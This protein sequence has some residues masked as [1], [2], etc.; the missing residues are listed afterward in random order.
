MKYIKTLSFL[1]ILCLI[2]LGMTAC[3]TVPG[4]IFRPAYDMSHGIL[5]DDWYEPLYPA[6]HVPSPLYGWDRYEHMCQYKDGVVIG[7]GR[8]GWCP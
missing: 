2:G 3:S 7:V 5:V 1:I 6:G 8:Q 4:G